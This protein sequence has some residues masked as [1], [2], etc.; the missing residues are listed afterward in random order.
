MRA[1]LSQM[2][3]TYAMSSPIAPIE[4]DVVFSIQDRI[5]DD[6][7]M[8]F[9]PFYRVI[10]HYTNWKE[11]KIIAGLIKQGVPFLQ[12]SQAIQTVKNA[13]AYGT[14]IVI[15][16]TREDAE[17]YEARLKRLGLKVSLDMA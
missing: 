6:F 7:D 13:V 8:T 12:H 15:T 5:I 3:R 17:L 16:A 1:A 4:D 11:D 10:L 14:A 2:K 9:E